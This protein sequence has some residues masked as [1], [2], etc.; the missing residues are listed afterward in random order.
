MGFGLSIA[1]VSLVF[2]IFRCRA[3]WW[4]DHDM[5]VLTAGTCGF[6]GSHLG[7]H[8]MESRE[9]LTI[10]GLAYLS[11]HGS[12][13]NRNPLERFGVQLFH[14]DIRVSSDL[15]NLSIVNWSLMPRHAHATRRPLKYVGF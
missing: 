14:G 12:E 7:C 15:E 11:R 1:A 4:A 10:V 9:G 5:K 2:R 6:T 8:L 13:K 3:P